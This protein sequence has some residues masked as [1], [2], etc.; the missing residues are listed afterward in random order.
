MDLRQAY[1]EMHKAGLNRPAGANRSAGSGPSADG[2]FPPACLDYLYRLIFHLA[3][4]AKNRGDQA[5]AYRHLPASEI[6]HALQRQAQ[7]DFGD[8]A[9]AV[10][11]SWGIGSGGD[12]GRAIFLLARF[13]CLSL[14]EGESLEEYAAAG[15]LRFN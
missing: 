5:P 13:N 10:M 4:S 7:A 15:R 6:C 12:I 1:L 9:G 14:R 2:G 3:G 11:E 8:L